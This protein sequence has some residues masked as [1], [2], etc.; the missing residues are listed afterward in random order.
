MPFHRGKAKNAGKV[1]G[2]KHK[3]I[4]KKIYAPEPNAQ[5]KRIG[6][7][8]SVNDAIDGIISLTELF[9]LLAELARD[10]GDNRAKLDAIKTL[11]A[12]RIG[13]PADVVINKT[14]NEVDD[15]QKMANIFADALMEVPNAESTATT[16][17]S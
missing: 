1:K 9:Q 2:S 6:I 10:T 13:K 14:V 8:Q 12:Y 5:G 3:G 15:L 11:L 7:V 16:S 17:A 4:P